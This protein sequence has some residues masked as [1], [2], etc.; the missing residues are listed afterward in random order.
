MSQSHAD[1][2]HGHYVAPKALLVKIFGALVALTILT[3]LT[4]KSDLIPGAL[5]VPLALTIATV[6]VALVVT[7]FMGLKHDNRINTVIFV[8]TCFFVLVFLSFTTFEVLNRGDLGNVDRM[9]VADRA[10]LAQ[11]DSVRLRRDSLRYNVTRVA[12]AEPAVGTAA[13]D[14]ILAVRQ[15]VRPSSARLD[16]MK[17][18]P[19]APSANTG[20][21]GA[22]TTPAAA[23]ADSTA[24]H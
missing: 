22:T 2:H 13:S 7:F 10:Y 15:G 8:L 12:G 19:A 18:A 11:Q 17:T 24:S 3:V 1:E 23:P 20:E 5:H 4:G 9:T 6:K 14:S 21:S 16:S